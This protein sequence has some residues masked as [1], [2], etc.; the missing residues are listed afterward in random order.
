MVIQMARSRRDEAR[1][2]SAKEHELVEQTRH[3]AI[4][5]LNDGELSDLVKRLRE[6]RDR[7]RDMSRQQRR[8][9]RGKSAPSGA[10]PATDNSGTQEKGALLAAA[11]K[12]AS[13]ENER[14]RREAE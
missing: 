7:A 6:Q 8:E 13:K 12:R 5:K 14:R 11:L 1:L 10:R 3:P 9:L 4:R 2:L